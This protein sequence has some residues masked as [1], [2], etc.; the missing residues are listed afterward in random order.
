MN[1]QVWTINITG[2]FNN[3]K[4][5]KLKSSQRLEA[6]QGQEHPTSHLVSLESWHL[7]TILSYYT[8]NHYRVP[9][10]LDMDHMLEDSCH[11]LQRNTSLISWEAAVWAVHW[12]TGMGLWE[13][14]WGRRG[15][16]G[17]GAASTA[18]EVTAG[19]NASHLTAIVTGSF[20][21]L[22]ARVPR[23][24]LL[25]LLTAGYAYRAYLYRRTGITITAHHSMYQGTICPERIRKLD[26]SERYI[27]TMYITFLQS[28]VDTIHKLFS[29]PS[30]FL[31]NMTIST[32]CIFFI[33]YMGT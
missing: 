33:L 14:L 24:V 4:S 8:Y 22:K 27:C 12:S 2:R 17:F 19:V 18:E 15:P 7:T 5:I 11:H 10:S 31:I 13:W 20:A 29:L 32:V 16:S 1:S 23:A 6:F 21:K 25:F 26:K 3:S 28:H 9:T 30:S